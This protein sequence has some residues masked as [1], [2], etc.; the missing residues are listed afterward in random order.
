MTRWKVL[1]ES[2]SPRESLPNGAAYTGPFR[3]LRTSR[4]PNVGT[5]NHGHACDA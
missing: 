1:W 2:T 4:S 3:H 5:I